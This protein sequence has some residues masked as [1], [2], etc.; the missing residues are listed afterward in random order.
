MSL[1]TAMSI[2]LP[3]SSQQILCLYW[4]ENPDDSQAVC[5]PWPT[6]DSRDWRHGRSCPFVTYPKGLLSLCLAQLA[7][8]LLPQSLFSGSVSAA[9]FF[10][11]WRQNCSQYSNSGGATSHWWLRWSDSVSQ[12]KGNLLGPTILPCA[13]LLRSIELNPLPGE[14]FSRAYWVFGVNV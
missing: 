10:W 7:P 12:W 1:V 14:S 3:N 9:A 5:R 2:L 11:W 8:S 4:P 6:T 13:S